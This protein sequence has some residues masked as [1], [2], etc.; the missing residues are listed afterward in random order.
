MKPMRARALRKALVLA[1]LILC[2]C[3]SGTPSRPPT[4]AG[5]AL[6]TRCHEVVDTMLEAT[7]RY[8]DT[9]APGTSGTA[10]PTAT[11][12]HTP[13]GTASAP[14]AADLKSQWKAANETMVRLGCDP[15]DTARDLQSKWSGLHAEGALARAVLAQLR[16]TLLGPTAPLSTTTQVAAGADLEEVLAQAPEG[17]T[18]ELASGTY[19]LDQS[20]VVLRPVTLHGAGRGRTVLQTSA[21]DD[22]LLV[23]TPGAVTLRDLSV[24]HTG[25]ARATVVSATAGTTLTLDGVEV[26]GATKVKGVG[27]TGVL[28]AEPTGTD[29]DASGRTTTLTVRN[30]LFAGNQAGAVVVAGRHRASVTAS[31]FT[32]NQQ[33]GVCFLGTSDGWVQSNTLR[34]NEVGVAAAGSARPIIRRNTISGGQ[35]G[36]QVGGKAAATVERN[37]ISGSQRAAMIYLDTS[38]G[39]VDGNTCSKDTPGI[40]VVGKG[41][42]PYLKTNDCTVATTS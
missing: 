21:A 6:R 38:A 24:R 16:T 8:V 9:L 32:G 12:T 15:T 18:I 23:L 27:G 22:G 11:P 39:T 42:Y 41:P 29:T 35:V 25:T 17:A 37:T 28:M 3:D 34:D 1:V 10:E 7:Q 13:T 19:R 14:T 40:V 26:S 20:L 31:T 36:I 5:A 33:C 2:A 4:S 30:G